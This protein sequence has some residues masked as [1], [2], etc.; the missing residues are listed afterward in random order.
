MKLN[1]NR[2]AAMVVIAGSLSILQNACADTPVFVYTNRDMMLTLRKTGADGGTTGANDLEVNIG[3][4]S[5]YYGAAST[6]NV[7][8]YTGAQIGGAFD[9]LNDLSWSVGGMVPISDTGPTNVP[10]KT[11]WVTAP[12]TDPNVQA[13]PWVRNSSSTQGTTVGEMNSVLGNASFYSGTVAADPLKNTASVVSVPVGGGHEAGAFL[14]SLGNY[15]STFQGDVENT[16]SPTFVTDGQPSRSDLYELR[17]D[18]TGT[19]PAGKYLGYF[20]LHTDGTMVFVPPSTLPPAPKLT[21]SVS[22][23]T[24]TISFATTVGATYSLYLTNAAGLT[25]PILTWPVVSTNITGDGSSHSFQVNS[26]AANQF[27]SVVAH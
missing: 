15:K 18:S 22:G 16:T 19:Q 17:P 2:A 1:I 21:I 5:L 9:N 8:Q 10:I 25:T 14:G 27:Y 4:A 3:Q 20:E 12:R 6:V 13:A 7:S 26:S 11:I 23:G 24:S